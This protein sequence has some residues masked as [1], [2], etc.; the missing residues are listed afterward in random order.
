MGS[1]L[2]V[3]NHTAGSHAPARKQGA[4]E[5]RIRGLSGLLQVQMLYGD[6]GLSF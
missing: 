2:C 1:P 3:Q 5:R 4:R 6:E